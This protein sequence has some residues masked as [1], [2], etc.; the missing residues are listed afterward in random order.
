MNTYRPELPFSTGRLTLREWVEEDQAAIEHLFSHED[1]QTYIGSPWKNS[2]DLQWREL[3]ASVRE[4]DMDG[5]AICERD[6]GSVVG[7]AAL[8]AYPNPRDAEV[9]DGL[10]HFYVLS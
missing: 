2:G 10:L 6:S 8:V 9:N 5:L 1:V 3:F 7:H 4:R